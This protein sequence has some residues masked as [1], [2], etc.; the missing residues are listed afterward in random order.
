[1]KRVQLRTCSKVSREKC[2]N[3][4]NFQGQRICVNIVFRALSTNKL[5]KTYRS[6]RFSLI[7][8]GK[9]VLLKKK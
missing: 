2:L 5:G 4:A 1:M 7:M 6:L 9:N 8:H 3:N